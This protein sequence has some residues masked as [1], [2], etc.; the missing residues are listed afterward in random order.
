MYK[1]KEYSKRSTHALIVAYVALAIA[2]ALVLYVF[3]LTR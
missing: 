3:Y 2:L 1:G